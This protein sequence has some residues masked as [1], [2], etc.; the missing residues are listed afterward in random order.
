MSSNYQQFY[1]LLNGSAWSTSVK[2]NLAKSRRPSRFC[3]Q[4]TSIW[5]RVHGQIHLAA[6]FTNGILWHFKIGPWKTGFLVLKGQKMKDR[7]V[8]QSGF[9]SISSHPTSVPG[10]SQVVRFQIV[11]NTISDSDT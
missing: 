6:Q 1:Q 11:W 10:F 8:G 5:L 4:K 7:E 2:Q 9:W 3:P